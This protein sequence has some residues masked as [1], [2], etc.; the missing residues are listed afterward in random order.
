V[1]TCTPTA[2]PD[3]VPAG[4]RR[5]DQHDRQARGRHHHPDRPRDHEVDERVEP[6]GVEHPDLAVGLHVRQLDGDRV[7]APD[8]DDHVG[9][10]RPD[11]ADDDGRQ[12]RPEQRGLADPLEPE[13]GLDDDRDAD[14]ERDQG[15]EPDRLDAGEQDLPGEHLADRPV[16]RPRGRGQRHDRVQHG[17]QV[18]PPANSR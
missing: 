9:Q 5:G 10:Q 2:G 16:P 4:Q 18:D 15:G 13:L 8:D 17:R 6:L 1:P 14:E 12:Q 3:Q 7:P 11:L